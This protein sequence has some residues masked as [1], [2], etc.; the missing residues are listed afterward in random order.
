[1]SATL[2]SP[3]SKIKHC[4]TRLNFQISEI[5]STKI[6]FIRSRQKLCKNERLAELLR[7][8]MVPELTAVFTKTFA[9][10]ERG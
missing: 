9:S 10:P 3:A 1:M 5:F 2:V 6:H 4:D 7:K 8:N